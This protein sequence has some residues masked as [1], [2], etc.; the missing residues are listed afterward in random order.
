MLV[1]CAYT[2]NEQPNVPHTHLEYQI[3]RFHLFTL[4]CFLILWMSFLRS[5]HIGENLLH[6]QYI[7]IQIQYSFRKVNSFSDNLLLVQFAYPIRRSGWFSLGIYMTIKFLTAAPLAKII[8]TGDHKY[9]KR[10]NITPYLE[11]IITF[12]LVEK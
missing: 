5:R 1:Y 4:I 8:F 12:C 11:Q 6:F 7:K 3:F 10:D 9:T 2:L